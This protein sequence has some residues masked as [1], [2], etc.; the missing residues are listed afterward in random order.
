MVHQNS[1]PHL[2]GRL[3]LRTE[4]FRLSPNSLYFVRASLSLRGAS[5]RLRLARLKVHQS[6]PRSS[7]YTELLILRSWQAL[8]SWRSLR[9]RLA[10]LKVHQNIACSTECFCIPRSSGC[11][12]TPYTALVLCTRFVAFGAE[13]ARASTFIFC[14]YDLKLR[15]RGCRRTKYRLCG[16]VLL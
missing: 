9:L 15:S 2:C 7:G 3:F 11:R 5:L 4:E 16:R 14:S 10:R 8:T 12:R 6:A 1:L 13:P